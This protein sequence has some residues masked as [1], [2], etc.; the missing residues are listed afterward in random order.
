LAAYAEDAAPPGT[1]A[2]L[3]AELRRL[4]DWQGLAD[5]VVAPRGDLAAALDAELTYQAAGR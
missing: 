4:A 1:A 5:V 2:A 3:A